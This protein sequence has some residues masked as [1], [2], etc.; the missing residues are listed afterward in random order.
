VFKVIILITFHCVFKNGT[1]RT[2]ADFAE[3]SQT[4]QWDKKPQDDGLGRTARKSRVEGW[5]ATTSHHTDLSENI[6][7]MA[8]HDDVSIQ[9]IATLINT[10]CVSASFCM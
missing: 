4:V 1:S 8:V 3:V 2:Q 5:H 7:S 9:M 6:R 10:L